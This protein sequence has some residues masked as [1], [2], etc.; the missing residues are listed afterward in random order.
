MTL[1]QADDVY[2]ATTLLLVSAVC[3]VWNEL[4]SLG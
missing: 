4:F 2:D 1:W 3:C